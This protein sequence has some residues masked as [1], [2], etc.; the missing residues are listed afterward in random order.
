MHNRSCYSPET[1][2]S[3]VFDAE[4][5]DGEAV[6]LWLMEIRHLGV[7][8]ALPL[9]LTKLDYMSRVA[10]GPAERIELLRLM[11]RPLLKL[12]AGLPKP[13]LRD[14]SSGVTAGGVRL[15]Q[16]L[17][18]LTVKNLR[19][20]LADLDRSSTFDSAELDKGRR[21]LLRNLFRF[22]DRQ[23][24]FGL[25]FGQSVP[26]FTWQT[27]HDLYSYVSV[28]RLAMPRAIARRRG[29]GEDFDPG[30][31]YRR[32][33]L[34]GLAETLT[35]GRRFTPE[36]IE[37][38]T[39]YANT[40]KLAEPEGFVGEFGVFRVDV[41][42]D[43]PPIKVVGALTESFRGWVLIPDSGF[44]RCLDTEISLHERLEPLFKSSSGRLAH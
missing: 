41:S 8:Q 42:R 32:L 9:F 30:M 18:C 40:C 23:I 29:R 13:L 1:S 19:Q 10:L 35:D 39:A 38:V 43:G 3:A 15:E 37:E 4:E 5:L 14:H 21:W 44:F 26:P 24:R 12:A 7:A 28:R 11:K 6:R 33:L 25:I 34:L 22:L 20:A 27:L 2:Q 36:F 31:E 16:R 17:Y